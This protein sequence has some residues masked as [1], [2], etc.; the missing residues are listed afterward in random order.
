LIDVRQIGPDS[1]RDISGVCSACGAVLF[2]ALGDDEVPNPQ[3]LQAKLERTLEKHVAE[4][5]AE[6]RQSS[7]QNSEETEAS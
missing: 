2:A 1:E 4:A 5:H 7:V 3:R 6:P